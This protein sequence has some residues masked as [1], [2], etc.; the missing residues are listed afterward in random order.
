MALT[1]DSAGW[2]HTDYLLADLYDAVA[3]NT[4]VVARTVGKAKKPKPYPRPGVRA[5]NRDTRTFRAK[6]MPIEQM[7]RWLG[8]E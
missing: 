7:R 5:A 8:W 4:Y 1:P 6:P 2:S 3:W